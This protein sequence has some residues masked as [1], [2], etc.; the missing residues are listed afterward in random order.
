MKI[1]ILN[2][3]PDGTQTLLEKEVPEDFFEISSV[4]PQEE[5]PGE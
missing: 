2:V 3:A 5:A 1:T 4:P